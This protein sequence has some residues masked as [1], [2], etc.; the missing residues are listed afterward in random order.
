MSSIF[1]KKT[2]FVDLEA[3]TIAREPKS[4]EEC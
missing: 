4:W 3:A 1:Y 2:C